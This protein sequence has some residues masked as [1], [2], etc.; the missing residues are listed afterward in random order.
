MKCE[1]RMILLEVKSRW[2][3]TLAICKGSGCYPI[4]L[5]QF[6]RQSMLGLPHNYTDKT[7][8]DFIHDNEEIQHETTL[9]PHT[10]D[11]EAK[12]YW[13]GNQAYNNKVIELLF[14]KFP[15]LAFLPRLVLLGSSNSLFWHEIFN[16]QNA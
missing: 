11:T 4:T 6:K 7:H 13:E 5:L 12:S 16:R 1:M 10:G 8:N 15:L 9:L 3:W 14:N 2:N